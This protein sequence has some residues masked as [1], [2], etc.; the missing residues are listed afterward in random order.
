MRA[1]ET[2]HGAPSATLRIRAVPTIGPSGRARYL[3]VFVVAAAAVRSS[4]STIAA[5]YACLVGTSIWDRANR[6]SRTAIASARVG[7]SGM[8]INKMFEGRCV[9]TIVFNSPKRAPTRAAAIEDAAW[10]SPAAKITADISSGDAPNRRS[11]Q[12]TMNTVTMNPPANES[13][14]NSDARR[15]T[16]SRDRTRG[17]AARTWSSIASLSRVE[18]HRHT[19]API[20]NRRNQ[21]R[22]VGAPLQMRSRNAGP[23]AASAPSAPV[24]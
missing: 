15:K 5:R 4:G 12:N 6:R 22:P 17:A 8:Q 19:T 23:P 21:T 18:S 16:R 9:N 11:N 10:R 13:I 20:G 7:I 24:R 14:A 1:P 2:T 3:A